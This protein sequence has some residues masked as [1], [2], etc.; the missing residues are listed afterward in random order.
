[1]DQRLRFLNIDGRTRQTLQALRPAVERHLPDALNGFYDVIRQTPEVRK[2]FSDER[3]MDMAKSGQMK[4]WSSIVSG[5]FDQTYLQ[6]VLTIGK[7]HARI[8]LEPRWYMGGYAYLTEFLV[9]AIIKERLSKNPFTSGMVKPLSEEIGAIIK[10]VVL[11]MDFAISTYL[12]AGE[13]A[14]KSLLSDM[15]DKFQSSV[16]GV[17]NTVAEAAEELRTTAEVMAE[18]ANQTSAQSATVAAAA[19]QATA[20]VTIVAS[21]ADEMGKSVAEI[22]H[23]VSHSSSIA[24]KAVAKAEAANNTIS[25]LTEAADRIGK[26]VNLI[27]DIAAQTNLLALNATIESARAGEAGRGFGV[28]ASEVKGLA[29][30]TAKATEDVTAQIAEIQASTR[31]SVLA[32]GEIQA[33]IDEMN[34]VSMAINAAVEEQSAATREIARSTNEAANGARDVSHNITFVLEGAQKT[35][36]ASSQVVSSSQALGDQAGLLRGQ[37]DQFL[38][39]VRAS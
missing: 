17:V 39:T 13:E 8:G 19:E 6:S 7:T 38:R 36:A 37:M 30:Q 32:L 34:S 22:A 10:A 4:H 21:S 11:D 25:R 26:V 2:F 31:E 18:T 28:V 29:S 16:A 1:M 9:S 24:A 5:N 12:E 23:Q 15:A 3:M 35:G 14:R 20:N 33:I 27:S